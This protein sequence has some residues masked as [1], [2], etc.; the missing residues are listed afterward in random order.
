MRLAY[1]LTEYPKVSHT[2]IRRELREMER[3]GHD[4]LRLA[5]RVTRAT[6]ADP[7]DREEQNRTIHCLA[8]P[9]WRLLAAAAVTALTR[10]TRFAAALHHALSAGWRSERGVARHLAYLVEACFLRAVLEREGIEHVHAHFGTNACGVARLIRRLGGPGY[11]F[12]VHGP[13][14]FD[15]PRP[16][17][18]AGKIHDAEFV[19]AITDFC[20]AQLCRW[21]DPEDWSKIHVVHCIVD[22]AFFDAARSLNE[23]TRTFV[24]VGRLAP[25]KGQPL[26]IDAFA[27]LV[28]GGE[29]ARLVLVGDGELRPRLE[30]QIRDRGIADRVTITGYVSEAEVRRHIL[31]G[32]ALVLPSFAE[33]LPM[34][35][36][37]AF[38]LGRPVISTYVAGIPELV[39]PGENG[40]LVP[41][42]SVEALTEAMRQALHAPAAELQRRAERGRAL[43]RERHGL[44][45]IAALD[46]LVSGRQPAPTRPP[47]PGG[48]AEPVVSLASAD[49]SP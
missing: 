29:D 4:V 30:R 27:D 49:G 39:R 15:A 24:S 19:I 46:A 37:E 40:W 8:Q 41:A 45:Q 31:A 25:Q 14:E 2:F 28:D 38:A 1:L 12:T 18:M 11:S 17:D 48:E 23:S 35:I 5:I 22:D 42:G 32:R 9:W 26:L 7:A 44:S 16:L 10:P 33:G 20:R 6:L 13:D 43:T 34:V 21:S 3:R 47:V 36:M